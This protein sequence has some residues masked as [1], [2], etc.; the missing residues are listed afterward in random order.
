MTPREREIRLRLRDD[1][2]HYATKCLKIRTKS[3][4]VYPFCLNFAQNYLHSKLEE[5]KALTKKVRALVLKGRQQGCSTYTEGRFFHKVTH[6]RGT[7]AFILTHLDEATNNLFG[8]AK[9][10]YEHCPS[11]VRP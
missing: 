10:F 1:F 7:R 4:S 3:G 5:Q 2:A 11:L 6:R 9:R 8:M